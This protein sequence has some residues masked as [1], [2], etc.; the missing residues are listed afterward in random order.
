MK[1]TVSII[2]LLAACLLV[3][4]SASARGKYT[5][6]VLPFAAHSAENIEYVRQG[7]TE[8]LTSR[9]STADRI[10]V[11]PKSVAMEALGGSGAKDLTPTEVHNIGRQL[12]SDYVVWGS[13]TKIGTSISI[14]GKLTDIAG[15]K[16]DISVFSQS[17]TLDEVIPKINDFSQRILVHVLGDS[18]EVAPAPPVAAQ[19]TAAAPKP[20]A[21]A[22]R[23]AQIIA[24]MKKSGGK[25][26][27]TSMINPEF[28]NASDPV[29]RRGFWMSQEFRTEFAG[30]AIGDVNNDGR[31]EIV[32][33]DRHNIYIYRKEKETLLL[34]KKIAGKS[35]DQYIS[36]DVADINKDGIPEIIVTSLR[37]KLL[38]SF[39][40]QYKDGE[41][42]T[43]ASD[44]RFFLRVIDTPSGMPMLLGQSYGFDKVFETQ[45]YE[46]VFR[47]GKYIEG[48]KQPFPLG[49]SI[50]G[51]AIED[52]GPGMKEKIIAF[53]ELDYLLVLTPTQ[54][55]LGRILSFGFAPEE[56]LWRS[57][58]VYGGSNNFI[59]NIDKEKLKSYEATEQESAF[60]NTRLLTFDTN[61]DGKKELIVIK[62]L[63]SVGRIFKKLK[64]FT[65]SEIHNLEWDGIGMAENWRT[66]KING[67]VADYAIMDLDNDSKPKII[68][69]LVKSVGAA[70][71]DRS[72]LVIYELE[73]PE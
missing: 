64:L 31:N 59:A 34:L 69:A 2:F 29:N 51:L 19:Q 21:A 27:F 12:K 40:I 39:V 60:A 52:L 43:I 23:E 15:G 35:Y 7:I 8:M 58:E 1:K 30:M 14:D 4:A 45:I 17:Q 66:K 13:I 37:E 49:L 32:I 3:A 70:V 33:V 26:T 56:L 41:Y 25:G 53:D 10:E 50:Y 9:L 62:N 16:S 46:I 5:I 54:K 24:G 61:R 68:L 55:T 28:I 65:S 22:S 6:T 67:Y 73:M 71:S 38:N 44:I 47:N 36:V 20:P 42:K 11:T 18:P 63:S 48:D 72:V 57:D